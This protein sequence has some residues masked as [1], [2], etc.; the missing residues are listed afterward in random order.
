MISK[1]SDIG[2]FLGC[3][4]FSASQVLLGINHSSGKRHLHPARTHR[5]VLFLK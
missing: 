4:V 1:L 3:F 2:H 5:M